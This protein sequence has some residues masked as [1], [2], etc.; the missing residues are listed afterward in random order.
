MSTMKDKPLILFYLQYPYEDQVDQG[1]HNYLTNSNGKRN[2]VE[3]RFKK[4]D[5]RRGVQKPA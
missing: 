4:N 2:A 5:E 3:R 1:C